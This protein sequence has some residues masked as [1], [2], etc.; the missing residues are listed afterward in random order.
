MRNLVL[1][2]SLILVI[3]GCSAQKEQQKNNLESSMN[4]VLNYKLNEIED[5]HIDKVSQWLD[6]ARRTGEEG[7]YFT[8]QDNT[9]DYI[10]SYVYRK[11]YS[12]Y[13]VSFIYDQN[14]TSSKGKVHVTG[15]SKNPT[16][17]K[18]IQIKMINDLSVLFI[19]SDES[20]KNKLK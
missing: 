11:G 16:D 15:L 9:E 17:D 14:D 19:L 7:Q 1:I 5:V 6:N 2:F 13:E 12:N 18:F 10:Y 20:L 3:A 8:F 4:A